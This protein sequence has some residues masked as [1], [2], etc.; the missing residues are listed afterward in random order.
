MTLLSELSTSEV[1]LEEDSSELSTVNVQS[2]V[3]EQEW[4]LYHNVEVRRK[5]VNLVY[6]ASSTEDNQQ[7]RYPSIS[8]LC[9]ASR[10]F[11]FYL[12]NII[13]VMVRPLSHIVLTETTSKCVFFT[14]EWHRSTQVFFTMFSDVVRIVLVG[15]KCAQYSA[16]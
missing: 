14:I 10:R 13:F 3:D 12:S 5:T 16:C 15:F 9:H 8:V 4:R 6:T 2:F 7:C 1:L 11:G